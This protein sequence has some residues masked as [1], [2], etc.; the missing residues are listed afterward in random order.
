M[1][2][3][4]VAGHLAER[5]PGASAAGRLAP[6]AAAEPAEGQPAPGDQAGAAYRGE[7]RLWRLSFSRPEAL[8]AQNL[9]PAAHFC[10]LT[11]RAVH[12]A[13]GAE[14]S[15]IAPHYLKTCVFWLCER[16]PPQRWTQTVSAMCTV[17][18]TLRLFATA[19]FLPNFLRPSIN[20]LARPNAA[21]R[22]RLYEQT[23]H[24]RGQLQPLLE[25][26]MNRFSEPWVVTGP[27]QQP[28]P[29][30]AATSAGSQQQRATH[31]V[32]AIAE[33]STR[34]PRDFFIHDQVMAF[35]PDAIL[36]AAMNSLPYADYPIEQPSSVMEAYHSLV[37]PLE[38]VEFI[39]DLASYHQTWY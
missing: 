19:G 11:L 37:E 39:P 7:R 10:L 29:S 26:P 5:L 14:A 34:P 35:V 16:R 3:G 36:D 24:L 18:D 33:E 2:A 31:S 6:A 20:V 32:M 12:S 27:T 8:L 15:L 4:G 25:D 13:L 17:L 30:K 21:Y 9:P 38:D 23:I 22:R 28:P 1:P